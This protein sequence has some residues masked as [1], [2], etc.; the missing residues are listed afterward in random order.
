MGQYPK[1]CIWQGG[2]FDG[3]IHGLIKNYKGGE[4]GV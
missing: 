4:K 1:E 3:G 2:Y